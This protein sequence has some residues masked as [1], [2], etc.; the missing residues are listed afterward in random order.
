MTR[1]VAL[2]VVFAVALAGCG[3]FAPTGD[4][5]A[6]EETVTPLPVPTDTATSESLSPPPGVAANGSVWPSVIAA[7]HHRALADRSFTWTLEYERRDVD[8]GVAVDSISKRMQVDG[9]RS[10]LIRTNRS[11]ARRAAL[12]A[13]EAGTYSREVR[14]DSTS[15]RH[16][17]NL[18]DY[19]T[20]LAT[21]Q[22]LRAY[23]TTADASVSRVER[24]GE[25]YYRVHVTVLP[26]PIRANHPKQTI[27][28]YS[29]TAYLTP[30]GRVGALIV[31]YD[32]TFG[33]DHVGVSL[34]TRYDRVGG[35]TVTRPDWANET[36]ATPTAT[37][38]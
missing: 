25:P 18:T 12:Y 13:D 31:R 19:R 7:A 3:A 10:Y 23:L 26:V 15:V 2:A 21:A 38:R 17:P 14:N 8:A 36:I 11:S 32:Y 20:H 28:N 6:P 37:D 4:A 22:S 35:T 16:V 27:H 9:D 5:G 34:R 33:T 1:R 30:E 24:R 29:A